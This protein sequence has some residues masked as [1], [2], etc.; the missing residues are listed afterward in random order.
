M[1]NKSF[2]YSGGWQR[3]KVPDHVKE[4]ILVLE[5]GGSNN[6]SGARVSGRMKVTGKQTLFIMVGRRGRGPSGGTG[7][8]AVFGGGGEGGQGVGAPGGWGGGGATAIRLNSTTGPIKAVAGGAGGDS[9]D[10]GRG[11]RG[12]ATVGENG[13]PAE[14]GG[15]GDVG[16]ATGGT[17]IQGGNG[18]T[19]TAGDRF[20]GQ[21]AG[22]AALSRAGGGGGPGDPGTAGGGAGGGGYRPGGGGQAG[23]L[24]VAPGGGGGGGSSF[25]G[26]LFSATSSQ[27]R[28]GVDNGSLSISWVN[29]PPANQPPSPPTDVKVGGRGAADEQVTRVRKS[30]SVTAKVDDPNAGQRVRLVAHWSTKKDFSSQVRSRVSSPVNQGKRAKVVLT[31]LSQ[32]TLYYVR[33]HTRD[34]HGRTS[35]RYNATSFWTNRKPSEPT[36]VFP[37]DGASVSQSSSTVFQWTH[38]DPDPNSRQRAFQL[39]WRVAATPFK[40]AG[41]W[42]TKGFTTS[43]NQYVADPDTFKANL[44]YEWQVRTEDEQRAW[45]KWSFTS[46]FFVTGNTLSPVP[47][48]PSN[49][50]AVDV[51]LP[52]EFAWR[53]RDPDQADLQ[54]KADLRYRVVGTSDWVTRTGDIT[55]PGGSQSWV[56][57]ADTFQPGYHYEYQVRTTDTLSSATSDWSESETFW[58]IVTPGSLVTPVALSEVAQPKPALGVGELRAFVFKRGGLFTVDQITPVSSISWSRP[59]DDIGQ[60]NVTTNGYGSRADFYANLHT[61]IY[62]LVIFRDDERIFEG[63]ITRIAYTVDGVELEAKDVMGWVYRRIIRQGYNDSYRLVNGVV[64]GDFTVVER[65]ARIIQNALAP[66]DP[67]I[68]PY[69]TTFNY[70]DDAGESRVVA[71]YT[72]TAWEEV[73]DMAANAGLDYTT[74]GRRIILNDTHRPVGRLAEMRDEN[75]LS[76]P[77]VTEYGMQLATHYGVTNGSGLFGVAEQD[78]SV[79]G[80]VELLSSAYGETDAASDQVLTSEAKAELEK[81][82][83]SQADRNIASRYPAPVVVRVPDNS[84]LDPRTN[85]GINDL[86]PGVWIPVRTQYTGRKLSQWQKLD[87]VSGEQTGESAETVKVTM[88]PA[89]NQGEDPDAEGVDEESA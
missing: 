83:T 3:F 46:S 21:N 66:D 40:V 27:G 88:S 34:S 12:G 35:T 69:L 48:F 30:I 17:A 29:P 45:G 68:L 33:L 89:P 10:G 37:V 56:L 11:G 67:N 5:G 58:G 7:G 14:D 71:P 19:S 52:V 24:G 6:V 32:D 16:N 77:I 74:I 43:F 64:Q 84:A 82:L 55:T 63:P 53:F 62:E 2:S 51:T 31:G 47:L 70:S 42:T 20:W 15:A 39:R 54:V 78:K 9:G 28:G 44:V 4:L 50:E 65:A 85:I 57:A 76:S 22:N 59:R 73:D 25:T 87:L 8:A 60:A 81:T 41:E 86:V 36:L 13:F 26:G 72:K 38:Q 18:G 1:G 80:L 75:F 61:W 49:S 79:Y 23:L